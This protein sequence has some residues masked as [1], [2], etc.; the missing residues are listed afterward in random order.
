MFFI[1]ALADD[2]S[3]TVLDLHIYLAHILADNSKADKLYSADK[4]DD[5]GHTCP[6]R[7]GMTYKSHN[8]RPDNAYKAYDSN[9]NSDRS[10]KSQRLYTKACNAVNSKV[11]HLFR[12]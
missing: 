3:G 5:T 12:G 8:Y 4:A 6:A 2:I 11:K 10:Y 9:Y 1:C 7:N